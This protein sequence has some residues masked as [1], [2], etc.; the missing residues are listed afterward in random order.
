VA[1]GVKSTDHAGVILYQ[2]LEVDPRAE[3]DV[4]HAAFRTLARKHHPDHSTGSHEVMTALN[5]AWAVLGNADRRRV[6]DAAIGLSRRSEATPDQGPEAGPAEPPE[7]PAHIVGA[8]RRRRRALQED[9]VLDFGRYAGRSL[10]DVAIHDRG[11]LE[12]LV[13]APAGRA[14]RMRIEQAL[15]SFAGVRR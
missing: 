1:N 15:A 9:P 4:I 13:R 12:W 7:R 2:L 14:W 5:H 11:Y 3:R 6:Y 8:I 10:T